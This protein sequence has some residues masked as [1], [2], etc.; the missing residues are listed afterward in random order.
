MD[1]WRKLFNIKA[2]RKPKTARAAKISDQIEVENRYGVGDGSPL[3]VE[4]SANVRHVFT[5]PS[6]PVP[7][8]I[9][10]RNRKYWSETDVKVV[11]QT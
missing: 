1:F 4:R 10:D 2:I 9:T 3:I 8:T 11:L 7:Q 5:N 6:P